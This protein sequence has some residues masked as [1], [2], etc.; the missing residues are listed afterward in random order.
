[1]H[2]IGSTG[3]YGA[4]R[5]ILALMKALQTFYIDQVHCTLL[6]LIDGHDERSA[7]VKIAI[8]RGF[9]AYDF[10]TGGKLNPLSVP[11]LASKVRSHSVQIIHAHG[12]KS[13]V[14]GLLAG[15][16]TG[17]KV[18]TT[19]HGWSLRTDKKEQ[20][21]EILDRHTLRYM[22][23]VC[24]LSQDLE[25]GLKPIISPSSLKLI[26]NGVDIDEV[27]ALPPAKKS[28]LRQYTIGYV[29]RLIKSKD[30][31]TLIAAVRDICI[32]QPCVRLTLIGDGPQKFSLEQ[33]TIEWCL[34]DNITFLGYQLKAIPFLKTFDLFVLPS[35]TEGIPRCVMEAMAAN[36]PVVVSNIPG[37]RALVSHL[38]TGLLF[39]PGNTHE[40]VKMIEYMIEHPNQARAMASRAAKKIEDKYSSRRMAEN[41]IA[42]YRNLTKL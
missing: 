24:P 32:K 22:D 21:Y 12:Y 39:E 14:M 3:V 13:D 11:R 33:I 23:M 27:R 2:L 20:L 26:P 8:Q 5:W 40:L 4:E 7:I 1:M 42:V 17:C 29:G 19:P 10:E 28:N 38:E 37:N 18:M 36:I 31:I 41:Y 15:R 9:D 6:N 25:H 34:K 16:I 35:L 30:L